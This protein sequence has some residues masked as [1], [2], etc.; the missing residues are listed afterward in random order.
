MRLPKYTRLIVIV[1]AIIAVVV[2][3]LV[4]D[5]SKPKPQ[6][7]AGY[8]GPYRNDKT[9][10]INGATINAEEVKTNEELQKGL[11]GRPCIL[12]NQAMLFVFTKP[13]NYGFWMKGMRFPVDIV[14]INNNHQVVGLQPNLQPSTYP[15]RFLN[16]NAPAQY[17][18]E[19]EAGRAKELGVKPG[20]SVLF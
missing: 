6:Q 12:P 14:W 18:L 7:V 8:C 20:T 15:N 10:H 13:G 5:E 2:I 4:V 17:V 11:A 9:V 16:N 19:L 3:A 1:V